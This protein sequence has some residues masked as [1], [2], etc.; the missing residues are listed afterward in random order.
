[1]NIFTHLKENEIRSLCNH[2]NM[3]TEATDETIRVMNTYDFSNLQPYFDCLFDVKKGDIAVKEMNEI[4]K[5]EADKGFILLATSLSAALYTQEQYHEKGISDDIFYDTMGCFSR[6]VKEHKVSY[7]VYG[8]DRFFWSYRQLA[9]SLF[10]IGTLEFELAVFP[11]E[12]IVVN[13][14]T[15]LKKNEPY[16]SIH[17]PSDARIDKAN[18]HDSY[19]RANAFF[20]KYYPEFHYNMFYCNSWIISPNLKKVLPETSNIIQFLSDFSIIK[21]DEDEEGY[22]TWVFKNSNLTPEQ[23]PEDTSLQ[24]NIKQ[25]VLN[26]GKIGGARGVI[27]KNLF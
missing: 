13:G 12:D 10:R 24:R 20:A 9:Q 21:V 8:F 16:L 2:I 1:M 27:D 26:G 5:D 6:F 25:H 19:H 18:N 22:K 17:I 14:K 11:L 4:L 3:P 7:G 23:F 15:L